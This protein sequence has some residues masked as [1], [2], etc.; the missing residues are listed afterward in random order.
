MRSISTPVR[1]APLIVAL[2][3]LLGSALLL[4]VGPWP[5]PL[6]DPLQLYAYLVLAP[7]CLAIGYLTGAFGTPRTYGGRWSWKWVFWCCAI[8]TI[9]LLPGTSKARSGSWIPNLVDGL[10]DPGK[11]YLRAETAHGTLNWVEYLRVLLGVP[12]TLL[13]PLTVYR[14]RRLTWPMRIAGLVGILGYLSIFVAIGTN[15]ALADA[16]ILICGLGAATVITG[17]VTL[18]RRRAIQLGGVVLA[19][20]AGFLVFFS[21]GQF[22]RGGGLAKSLDV[23]VNL[24]NWSSPARPP[25]ERYAALKARG[26]AYGAGPNQAAGSPQLVLA[27]VNNALIKPLPA[28]LQ[29][30]AISLTGYLTEG[31]F[32]LA[33]AM[34][35]PWVPT[36]GVGSAYFVVRNASRLLHSPSLEDRPY[37]MRVETHVGWDAWGR[38]TAFYAWVASDLSFPGTLLLM[39]LI[40]RVLALSWLDTVEGSNPFAIGVFGV[41]VLLIA[42]IPANNQV[43]ADGET[44]VGFVGLLIL[45]LWTRK[46]PRPGVYRPPARRLRTL[47]VPMALTAVAAIAVVGAGT[48]VLL[49]PMPSDRFLARASIDPAPT[50]AVPSR[51]EL[52]S[53]ATYLGRLARWPGVIGS[54]LNTTDTY[55][56]RAD[57][58]QRLQTLPTDRGLVAVQVGGPTASIARELAESFAGDVQTLAS[59]VQRGARAG[60]ANL[61]TFRW[62]AFSADPSRIQLRSAHGRFHRVVS[63]TCTPLVGCGSGTQLYFPLL[64]GRTYEVVAWVRSTTKRP[65]DLVLA[66]GTLSDATTGRPTVVRRGWTELRA[67]WTPRQDLD[68][69]SFAVQTWSPKAAG[70]QIG[71]VRIT[72]PRAAIGQLLSVLGVSAASSLLGGARFTSYSAARDAGSLSSPALPWAL[73][74]FV[75]WALV[76]GAIALAVRRRGS[77]PAESHERPAPSASIRRWLRGTVRAS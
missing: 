59:E 69:A 57:V 3:Y 70:F 29:R 72:A 16:A 76:A 15:K 34:Q 23:D 26:V 30:A 4:A 21:A 9:V 47:S 45:W 10:I 35:Q 1:L 13:L 46:R 32:G 22:T 65:A 77:P 18:T 33:L 6:P 39:L 25:E 14:W 58:K 40:G 51:A 38:W 24:V 60:V 31:Y 36:Y 5:W 73:F 12:L 2:I 44:A 54:V 11:A 17:Q 63:V 7:F 68:S 43:F 56:S 41:L 61:A 27:S 28:K 52:I 55:L 20:V 71:S 48:A 75:A 66:L 37:P 67:G 49:R 8:T 74:G 50:A 64:A 53:D 19:V 42:Y 62:G